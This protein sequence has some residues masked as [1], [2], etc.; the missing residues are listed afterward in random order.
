MFGFMFQHRQNLKI[1][2]ALSYISC[3]YSVYSEQRSS[4]FLHL[5]EMLCYQKKEMK[6]VFPDGE[7]RIKDQRS[8]LSLVPSLTA[9]QSVEL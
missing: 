8:D 6:Q 4:T 3:K 9:S 7:D 1:P 2:R 5:I